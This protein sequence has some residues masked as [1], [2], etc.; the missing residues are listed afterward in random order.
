MDDNALELL[1]Q[2]SGND[3]RQMINSL[4]LQSSAYKGM[5]YLEAKKRYNH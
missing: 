1:I 3:I 4:Q 2:S 5:T